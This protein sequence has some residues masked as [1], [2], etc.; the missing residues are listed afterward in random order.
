MT[1]LALALAVAGCG[2]IGFDTSATSATSCALELSPAAASVNLN[3]RVRF[4][5]TNGRAPIAFAVDT[6][7]GD[8]DESGTYFSP[9]EPGS[10]TIVATDA[11]S[12]TATAAVT[13][14]GSSLFYI[15][16]DASGPQNQVWRSDDGKTWTQVATAPFAPRFRC[17]AIVFDDQMW[18]VGGT[19]DGMTQFSDVFASTD[20]VTWRNA[21]TLPVPTTAMGIT[22]LGH[23]LWIVGGVSTVGNIDVVRSS[24]DGASW[25]DEGHFPQAAH[26]LRLVIAE[27]RMLSLGGHA[28][29]Q[30]P[31]TYSS[32]DGATWTMEAPLPA[33][34]ELEAAIVR[35]GTVWVGGG[36]TNTASLGDVAT[37]VD[38]NAWV[39]EPAFPTVRGE[40][41]F[42]VLGDRVFVAG[43]NDA[44][45]YSSA[46]AATWQLEGTLPASRAGGGFLSFTPH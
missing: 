39:M 44:N 18:I 34:R 10:A 17:G 37:T 36:V 33:A 26:G 23:Q 15:A 1:R 9:G 27:G 21:G 43:G 4:V 8:I 28:T 12:C 30:F 16:G 41:G 24:P 5:A 3:S 6:G 38:A 29:V 7:G 46:D 32:Y 25:T 2:R 20:G 42:A 45:V 13:T 14:A 35:A 31:D 11:D 19:P 22:V 40:T